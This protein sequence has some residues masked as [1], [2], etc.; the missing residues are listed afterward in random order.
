MAKHQIDLGGFSEDELR[1]LIRDAQKELDDRAAD[2]ARETLKEIRRLAAAVGLKVAVSKASSPAG[3]QGKGQDQGSRRKAKQKYRNPGNPA[4][5]WGGRGRPPKWVQ[6]ALER[7][8]S[9][10]DLAIPDE[11]TAKAPAA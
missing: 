10:N 11:Q 8:E 6:E 3:S 4:E 2:R 7:G 1:A 9:L 5:T